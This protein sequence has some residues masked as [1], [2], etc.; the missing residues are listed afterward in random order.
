MSDLDALAMDLAS[1]GLRA[2]L[3]AAAIVEHH[4]GQVEA[5]AKKLAPRK[6]LRHYADTI[7]HETK[8]EGGRIVGEAGPERKGQGNLGPIEEY[9]TAKFPPHSH[10]GPALDRSVPGF[11]AD[12]TALGGDVL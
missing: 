2:G 4:I 10:M 11:V 5:E 12:L 7:T 9:G 1:A 8:I 3:K 6:R